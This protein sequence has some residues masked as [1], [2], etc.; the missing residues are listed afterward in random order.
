MELE[1]KGFGMEVREMELDNIKF[2]MDV[3]SEKKKQE[4]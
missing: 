2:E 1:K 3:L 4:Q